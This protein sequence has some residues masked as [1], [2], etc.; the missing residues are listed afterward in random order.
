VLPKHTSTY[1]HRDGH[2]VWGFLLPVCD[3]IV[4]YALPNLSYSTLKLFRSC[5]RILPFCVSVVH[6]WS[7]VHAK[8]GYIRRYDSMLSMQCVF[9]PPFSRIGH[10]SLI[11]DYSPPQ[12]YMD[13]GNHIPSVRG[14]IYK[15][16]RMHMCTGVT[17]THYH[18]HAPTHMRTEVNNS[19]KKDEQRKNW[20]LKSQTQM[21]DASGRFH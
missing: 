6:A 20:L 14:N 18:A 2:I 7:H 9:F 4:A 19:Q 3:G 17:C 5:K 16:K 8:E 15:L 11:N 12:S 10:E 1:I 13:K 21:Y